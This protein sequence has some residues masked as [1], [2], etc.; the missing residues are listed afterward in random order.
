MSHGSSGIIDADGKVVE[1][2][3]LESADL[4]VAEIDTYPRAWI[5]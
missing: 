4:L 3:R 1:Q 2:A 5:P